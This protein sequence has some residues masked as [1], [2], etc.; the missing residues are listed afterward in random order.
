MLKTDIYCDAHKSIVNPL[1]VVSV[2]VIGVIHELDE[3]PRNPFIL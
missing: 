3:L 2:G 1:D